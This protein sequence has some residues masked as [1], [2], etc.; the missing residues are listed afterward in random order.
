MRAVFLHVCMGQHVIFLGPYSGSTHGVIHA[1]TYRR[2]AGFLIHISISRALHFS[3]KRLCA[4]PNT[5]PKGTRRPGGSGGAACSH[6]T[7]PPTRYCVQTLRT[8]LICAG[9]FIPLRGMKYPA[10]I[11]WVRTAW[12][13]LGAHCLDATAHRVLARL[14]SKKDNT[15]GPACGRNAKSSLQPRRHRPRR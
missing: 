7:I 4:R 2:A 12:D 8:Q 5:Y 3:F 9:Y 1:C 15:T 14:T 10:H 11:S 6:C 13:E